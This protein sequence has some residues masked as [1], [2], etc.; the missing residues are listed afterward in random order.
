MDLSLSYTSGAGGC[1]IGPQLRY[2]QM[3]QGSPVT[4]LINSFFK[5][6]ESNPTSNEI[7]DWDKLF[8]LTER[9][10]LKLFQDGKAS[11]CDMSSEGTFLHVGLRL[12]YK[13]CWLIHLQETVVIGTRWPVLEMTSLRM[14]MISRFVKTLIR[15]GVPCGELGPTRM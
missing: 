12:A 9:K 4:D 5:T 6:L 11:P 3:V 13:A 2:M 7:Q 14:D 15:A 1:S 10:L 8:V